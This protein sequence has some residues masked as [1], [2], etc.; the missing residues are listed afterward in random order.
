M[1]NLNSVLIEGNLLSEPWVINEKSEI[2]G[3]KFTITSKRCIKTNNKYEN[4][5]TLIDV[6]T[7]G[8]LSERCKQYLKPDRGVRIIGRLA[9]SDDKLIVY[10]EHVEFKP[11]VNEESVK[12]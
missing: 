3:V 10:A 5:I 11:V 6:V 12:A 4:E 8:H 9:Q 1:N 7:F 2:E